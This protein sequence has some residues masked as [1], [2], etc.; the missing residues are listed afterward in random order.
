MWGDSIGMPPSG[1][2]L[3]VT[4]PGMTTGSPFPLNDWIYLTSSLSHLLSA[5]LSTKSFANELEFARAD[6]M[7]PF[8]VGSMGEARTNASMWVQHFPLEKVDLGNL[9]SWLKLLPCGSKFGLAV[10]LDPDAADVCDTHSSNSNDNNWDQCSKCDLTSSSWLSMSLQVQ[11]VSHIYESKFESTATISIGF[12]V[13]LQSGQ[14]PAHSSIL[15]NLLQYQAISASD[16]KQKERASDEKYDA[17]SRSDNNSIVSRSLQHCYRQYAPIAMRDRLQGLE[18]DNKNIDSDT[19]K[20][21]LHRKFQWNPEKSEFRSTTRV[22]FTGGE[23]GI[24]YHSALLSITE[25]LPAYYD[26]VFQTYSYQVIYRE[27]LI[28]TNRSLVADLTSLR[29]ASPHCTSGNQQQAQCER[30]I[31]WSV[32]LP[33]GAVA[34]DIYFSAVVVGSSRFIPRH[35]LPPAASHGLFVPPTTVEF[36]ALRSHM[37]IQSPVERYAQNSSI[38]RQTEWF[39]VPVT[40]PDMSMPFNVITLVCTLLAFLVGSL[41]NILVLKP[42][43]VA[44]GGNY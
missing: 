5:S 14:V 20:L 9:R 42:L 36:A 21:S 7:K 34:M 16:G 8:L 32:E 17:G 1:S 43:T 13:V 6:E 2:V 39:L 24:L 27:G 15:N 31:Q 19:L 29:Y 25:V 22:N 38:I 35:K 12:S 23:D 3:S 41:I 40:I 18:K 10:F 26:I 37:S 30:A 33:S 28:I 44:S 4:F 11:L